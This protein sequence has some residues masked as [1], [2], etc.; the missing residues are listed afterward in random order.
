MA[1]TLTLQGVEALIDIEF[2]RLYAQMLQGEWAHVR[3][4]CE[5]LLCDSENAAWAHLLLGYT[6]LHAHNFDAAYHQFQLGSQTPEPLHSESLAGMGRALLGL[7][8]GT[9]ALELLQHLVGK[10]PMCHFAWQALGETLSALG[11]YEQAW[12]CAKRATQLSPTHDAS[13]ALLVATGNSLGEHAELASCLEEIQRAQPANL[14]VRGA[15]A[16]SLLR[17]QQFAEAADE[18]A[19]VIAFAPFAQVSP[20]VLEAI[21]QSISAINKGED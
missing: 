7:S 4:R 2:D 14:D 16:L 21:R 9:E 3:E 1:Y 13:M 5:E 6:E 19:R 12:L 10:Y 20:A 11:N 15:R 17:E 8:R 18:M